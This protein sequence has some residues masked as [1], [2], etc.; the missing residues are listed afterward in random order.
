MP[1]TEEASNKRKTFRERLATIK[2]AWPEAMEVARPQAKLWV[3]GLT[4]MLINRLCGLVLPGA[5]KVLLDQAF[6]QHDR[7]L[8]FKI[9]AA[10]LAATTIQGITSYALTQTISKA[11]QRTIAQLRIKIHDHVSRLPVRYYDNH[12]SG[13]V[14]SRVMNDVEGVRNL[15]GTGMVEFIGG[16]VTASLAFTILL[17]LN[18]RMT[19]AIGAFLSLFA[20]VM[21]KSF[22]VLRPIFKQRQKLTAEVSGRLTE[23]A[24][25]IRVV[26]SYA[27]EDAERSLFAKGVADL[28]DNV[29]RTIN[30]ISIVSLT[31]SILLGVLGSA[32]LFVGGNQLMSGGL[33]TGQF[34]SYLLYLGFMIAPVGSIVM[35][36]TNMSE[37]FAGLERM[38]EVLSE[39]RED[40]E[41]AAKKPIGR[42]TG[43]VE[44]VD[45][46]F[47]YD[48]G[49]I[50]LHNISFVAEPGQ[51]TALVGPSGGGKSTITGLISAFYKPLSGS[52]LID[53]QDLT[54]IR[55]RDYRSQ[56]GAVLQ[57]NFLFAGTVKEN[58]LYSR[59]TAT[60]AEVREAA[61]LAH[62]AEFVEAFPDG[63]E[64][65]IGERGVKL[66]GGQR[67][68]IAIARALLGEPRLLI[69]DEATSALDSESEHAIQQGLATLMAGRTTFVIAH[70]LST[71]RG[72]HQILVIEDGRIVERGKHAEL[73]AKRG[74]YFDMYSRQHGVEENLF[75]VPGDKV[76]EE[77]P[78]ADEDTKKR[79]GNT[80]KLSKL[81]SGE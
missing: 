49:K 60:D 61:R 6:P 5:P 16:I 29:M 10:V 50:V 43:R 68:R 35:I 51:V 3:L 57:D 41:E 34:I 24:A 79:V 58:I 12:K 27:G 42:V 39:P 33:T 37:A 36:G 75:V 66:S 80:D 23:S 13:E 1:R 9:I 46:S 15:F 65:I 64:T 11:G 63:F 47:E 28:L 30:A 71:I 72:A 14:V 2:R 53:G 45:L 26:K 54:T 40:E 44:F 77:E 55:L 74:R 18:W 32:I 31:T 19:A 38:R 81:L 4:L 17:Y 73:L 48:P 69:L 52:I 25:G 70:R 7:V 22:S 56:M 20:F 21:I 62:A 78:D 67:Q 8:L 59:P 76:P